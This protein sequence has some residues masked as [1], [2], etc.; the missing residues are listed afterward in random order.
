MSKLYWLE[1]YCGEHRRENQVRWNIENQ[2]E[3]N[4]EKTIYVI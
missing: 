4:K 1:K 3:L 2:E